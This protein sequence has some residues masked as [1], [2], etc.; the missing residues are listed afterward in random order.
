LSFR[1]KS[2]KSLASGAGVKNIA[3]PAANDVINIEKTRAFKM[4]FLNICKG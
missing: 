3:T 4:G 2:K 1:R